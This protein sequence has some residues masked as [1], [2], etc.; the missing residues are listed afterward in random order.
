MPISK[1]PKRDLKFVKT[2]TKKE[3]PKCGATNF[4]DTG[5]R[6]NNNLDG[7]GEANEDINLPEHPIFRCNECGE[8]FR[9][10]HAV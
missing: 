6:A 4:F 3:C 2:T 1:I 7:I 5:Y 9:T 10:R 8:L